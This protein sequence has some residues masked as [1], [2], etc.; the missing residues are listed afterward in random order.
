MKQSEVDTDNAL[1][2]VREEIEAQHAC[3]DDDSGYVKEYR[4]IEVLLM[5]LKRLEAKHV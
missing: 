3:G 1:E 5:K 2:F 4:R